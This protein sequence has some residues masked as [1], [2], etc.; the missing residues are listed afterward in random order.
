MRRFYIPELTSL[1]TIYHVY[2]WATKHTFT[3]ARKP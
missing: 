1:E 2:A 3:V